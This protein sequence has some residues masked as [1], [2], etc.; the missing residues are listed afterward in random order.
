M[1]F[2]LIVTDASPS[3]IDQSRMYSCIWNEWFAYL[4]WKGPCLFIKLLK[5]NQT[6][7]ITAV[8]R[9]ILTVA[10]LPW[11]VPN[12]CDAM[13]LMLKLP[14]HMVIGTLIF[15]HFCKTYLSFTIEI[16]AAATVVSLYVHIADRQEILDPANHFSTVWQLHPLPGGHRLN[17]TCCQ[18]LH[19]VN[20]VQNIGHSK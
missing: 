18:V 6:A 9:A 13:D 20:L 8:L 11:E 12:D 3:K 4:H 1:K 17:T 16:S 19:F 7:V 15:A 5:A 14:C 10:L 2:Q